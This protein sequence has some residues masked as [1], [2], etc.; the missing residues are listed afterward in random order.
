MENYERIIRV[1]TTKEE[2]E[3]LVK[4]YDSTKDVSQRENAL[5][6]TA[7]G[8]GLLDIEIEDMLK[9]VLARKMEPPVPLSEECLIAQ[10]P[11]GNTRHL[12][13]HVC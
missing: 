9:A 11:P 12:L 10:L 8:G 6:F 1:R 7:L 13:T 3:R 4:Y 5:L 2:R